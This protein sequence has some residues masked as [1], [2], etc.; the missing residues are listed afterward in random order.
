MKPGV[1]DERLKVHTASTMAALLLA[2]LCSS[3]C[4][5]PRT[6]RSVAV[7]PFLDAS[8]SNVDNRH[9]A[10][11]LREHLA[12]KLGALEG[13]RIAPLEETRRFGDPGIPAQSVGEALGVEAI[14]AG[15]LRVEAGRARVSLAL[16]EAASGRRVRSGDFEDD[17]DRLFAL[18]GAM[19][20]EAAGW[21]KGGLSE[22]DLQSL[23]RPP[24]R[25]VPAWD[26][27]LRGSLA[28]QADDETSL[29]LAIARFQKAVELDPDLAE[30]WLGLGAAHNR[31]YFGGWGD[32]EDRE[33]AES[34]LHR[35]L[36][37]D[38]R[39]TEART[40]LIHVYWYRGLCEEIIRQGL[41]ARE[42]GNDVESI[43][44]MA[45]AFLHAGLPGEALPLLETVLTFEP[46][47][48]YAHYQRIVAELRRGH[49]AEV[50]ERGLRFL[51]E[52]SPQ[53]SV[54]GDVLFYMSEAALTLGRVEEAVDYA[55]RAVRIP[56]SG[57]LYEEAAILAYKK[58]GRDEEARALINEAFARI[59]Q[60]VEENP[61]N[62][63]QLSNL[64]VLDAL[65][66][67]TRA[68]DH[69]ESTLLELAPDHMLAKQRLGQAWIMAGES[70]RGFALLEESQAAGCPTMGSV[71]QTAFLFRDL[72]QSTGWKRMVDGNRRSAD[73]LR[74]LA[75]LPPGEGTE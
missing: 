59:S 52:Y 68:L 44:V 53:G 6:H 13:I 51:E 18:Q 42:I 41:K 3:G 45:N 14:L 35:A 21:L 43:I 9:L 69:I 28:M 26:F 71:N 20:R 57:L 60:L 70:S 7:L 38:P 2:A 30:G 74:A 17:L 50:I 37:I 48:R 16:L 19:A 65:A 64:A 12:A 24:A 1:L 55:S 36:Q 10:D 34:F 31:L 61:R 63:R 23:G 62:V 47:H 66:G 15:A 27:Y 29:R 4:S 46:N 67:D 8:P 32:L 11:G 72:T 54:E 49:H 22:Q 33:R 58:A 73:R 56:S 39:L 25:S 75:G 40:G 5:E